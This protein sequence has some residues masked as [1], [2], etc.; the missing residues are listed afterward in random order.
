MFVKKFKSEEEWQNL[1]RLA[2]LGAFYEKKFINNKNSTNSQKIFQSIYKNNEWGKMDGEDFFSGH[3]SHMKEI[4]DNYVSAITNWIKSLDKKMSALDLGCG[5]FHIGSKIRHLFDSYIACDIVPELIL[6][7][8]EKFADFSVDFIVSDLSKD[9]LPES[10]VIIVRQVLQHLSNEE[11]YNFLSKIKNRYHYL[12]FTD[13]RSN[14]E[15]LAE[16]MDLLPGSKIRLAFGG[17]GLDLTKVPFNLRPISK[18]II[19]KV[20]TPNFGGKHGST[21]NTIVYKL[22]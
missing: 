21:I 7:N 9:E 5:D 18:E 11:I 1:K 13:H 10:D 3:G 8:S 16:N 19:S 4:V 15:N 2:D 22:K 20:S 14:D 6:Y 12:I 17:K